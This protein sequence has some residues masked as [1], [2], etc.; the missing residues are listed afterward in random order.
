MSRCRQP[1][2]FSGGVAVSD[3]RRQCIFIFR[4]DIFLGR[5]P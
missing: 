4:T 3:G 1:Y 5:K 2:F